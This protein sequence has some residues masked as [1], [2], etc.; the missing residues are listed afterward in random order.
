MEPTTVNTRP[1][2]PRRALA[3]LALA[4]TA[5]GARAHVQILTADASRSHACSTFDM[6][7]QTSAFFAT[8]RANL[9]DYT[10][11]GPGAPGGQPFDLVTT[12]CFTPDEL[13]NAQIVLLGPLSKPLQ[14]CEKEALLDF[15]IQGGSLFY[16]S[17]TAAQE[18]GATFGAVADAGG[19]RGGTGT[20]VDPTSPLVDGPFGRVTGQWSLACTGRFDD[21]GP[22]GTAVLAADEP[23]CAAFQLGQGR[24]VLFNDEEWCGDLFESGCAA[25]QMPDADRE[26]FFTNT[27]AWLQPYV[28]FFYPG[29][30]AC[31]GGTSYCVAGPN[32]I[33]GGA[34]MSLTGSTSLQA[35]AFQLE[36]QGAASSAPGV[37][38]YG[39]ERDQLPF[40]NG[41]ACI[42]APTSFLL[43][44]RITDPAGSA[45]LAIDLATSPLGSSECCTYTFQFLYRDP[46][47]GPPGFNLSDGLE[48]T[49][50]P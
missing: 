13:M 31:S 26:T 43:P 8:L 27:I 32:S 28:F 45:Q 21:V 6:A 35:N 2:S 39:T 24:A 25:G 3:A 9:F 11:F 41:F 18:L 30:P 10:K 16:F 5:A 36:V 14:A 48:V 44:V 33:G 23:I 20:V 49:I 50:V 46:L 42:A 47:A 1:T 38:L 17:N 4:V 34:T 40:G 19:C 37:F 7:I 29:G 22:F 12:C 15:V